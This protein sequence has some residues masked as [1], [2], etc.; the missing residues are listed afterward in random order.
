MDF[1]IRPMTRAEHKYSY[2]WGTAVDR[3]SVV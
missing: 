3:K 2:T 1:N